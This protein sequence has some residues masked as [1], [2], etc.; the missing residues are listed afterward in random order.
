MAD[1]M[2]LYYVVAWGYRLIGGCK[3]S[4]CSL[5]VMV[6]GEG[7][8]SLLFKDFMRNIIAL[9]WWLC[10]CRVGVPCETTQHGCSLWCLYPHYPFSIHIFYL[11]MNIEK[12]HL[13]KYWAISVLYQFT[14]IGTDLKICIMSKA[15]KSKMIRRCCIHN[16]FGKTMGPNVTMGTQLIVSWH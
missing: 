13:K 15:L 1:L 8:E 12:H 3:G 5:N 7:G 6:D 9:W 10:P 2:I 4:R 14:T 11:V 16:T